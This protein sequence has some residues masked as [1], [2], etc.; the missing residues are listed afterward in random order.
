VILTGALKEKSGRNGKGP[1]AAPCGVESDAAGPSFLEP[2]G[3]RGEVNAM[4]AGET[5]REIAERY[6][7]PERT[8]EQWIQAYPW[9][10]PLGRRGR[11]YVYGSPEADAAVRAILALG[12][13]GADPGELLDARQ[14]AQEAGLAYGT[15]RAYISKGTWPEPDDK[16]RRRWKRSTVRAFMASRRPHVRRRA[17]LE[18][19]G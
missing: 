16:E 4:V 13:P 11:Q 7:R 12:D 18:G 3:T 9:P 1:A 10:A 2:L 6:G 19:E 8:V 14:A 5:V 15:V 17:R